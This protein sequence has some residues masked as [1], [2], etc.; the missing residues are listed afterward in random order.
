[1][2]LARCGGGEKEEGTETDPYTM[3]HIVAPANQTVASYFV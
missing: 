2:T 1:V 3:L